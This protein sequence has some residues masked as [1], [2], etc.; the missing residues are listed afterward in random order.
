[1]YN[2]RAFELTIQSELPFREL[3]SH[4]ST[5]QDA[6]Q[7]RIIF[8]TVSPNGLLESPSLKT[9]FYEATSTEFW[10]HIPQVARFLI[11]N[12]N[13]IHIDPLPESD[14]DS[15]RLFVLGS[16][17]GALLMQRDLLLL[18]GNAIKIGN[19]CISFIG[20]SGAG[21]STLSGAFFKRGYSILADDVCAVN[22]FGKVLPSFPQIKLWADAA[23]QLMINTQ[24]LKKIRPTLDKFAVP[25]K[26]QFH[27]KATPLKM[28][29]LLETH[30]EK[31]ISM[32]TLE[33]M[34]KC[35]ALQHH[36]YRKQYLSNRAREHL[37]FKQCMMLASKIELVR[38]KRP[39]NEFKL[40][41]L[42][43]QIKIDLM[44]R[45]ITENMLTQ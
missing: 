38:I 18:H 17:M 35:H 40:D 45:G 6:R 44:T 28:V 11:T 23:S 27:N 26:Q 29:Y 5:E 8:S 32:K 7:I 31:E 43:N 34:E 41:T 13:Q 4:S 19:Q 15:I 30:N 37:C 20:D 1:M 16:C 22:Y 21:K 10:L 12:G 33:G 24:T 25:L 42:L 14:E 9:A 39:V 36:V 3:L 2:Y